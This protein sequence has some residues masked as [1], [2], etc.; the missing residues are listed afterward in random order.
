MEDRKKSK[1]PRLMSEM[2]M[3]VLRKVLINK[4]RGELSLLVQATIQWVFLANKVLLKAKNYS[5]LTFILIIFLMLAGPR[6]AQIS[7]SVS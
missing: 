1:C 6:P 7:N 3:C 4:L 5:F 2:L